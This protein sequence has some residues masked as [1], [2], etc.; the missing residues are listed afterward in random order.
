MDL[1]RLIETH[2]ALTVREVEP[3]TGAMNSETWSV[4]TDAG[5]FALKSVSVGDQGFVRGLELAALL[6]RQG[7]PVGA[8]VVTVG[9]SLVEEDGDRSVALLRWVE[10]EPL[11]SADPRSGPRMGSL[12]ARVHE[13]GAVEPGS[14][15]TW[16]RVLT[17][18]DDYLDFEPWNR[19]VFESTRRDLDQL[20]A[21]ESLT[22][23]GLHGDP[24][25]SAFLVQGDD[26][27]LI[28]WGATMYGPAL[29]DLTSAA[30]YLRCPIDEAGPE[31]VD[32]AVKHGVAALTPSESLVAAY[33]AAR[34][35]MINEVRRG[36][37]VYLRVRLC[38]QVGYFAW[39]CAKDIRTGIGSADE[40]REGL[41]HA[42]RSLG[43]T[44]S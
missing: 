35:G 34:P 24:S 30:M 40:N 19:P 17:I 44:G 26:T 12:L 29:Y 38:V 42:R 3:L 31:L 41:L 37:A 18:W 25:P 5:R 20:H 16:L 11:T 21:E 36:F 27:G 39:R 9:G 2:W 23:A 43:V 14:L 22:W 4:M 32:R 1:P 15:E 13:A 6:D 10:G 8:P 33:L 28:D 7:I